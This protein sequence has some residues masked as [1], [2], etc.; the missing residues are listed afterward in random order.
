MT[1]VSMVVDPSGCAWIAST[2]GIW[3]GQP[4]DWRLLNHALPIQPAALALAI[5]S[6]ESWRLLAAGPPGGIV[7]DAARASWQPAWVDEVECPVTCVVASPQFASDRVL[8][9]GT[10]R[11]GVL[12]STDGGRHWRLSS[13]GLDELTVLT[14]ATTPRWAERELVFA[15]T[16]RGL[17][18]SPNGGRAWKLCGLRE[19]VVQALAPVGTGILA[20]TEQGRLFHSTDQ[21]M[22]WQPRALPTD[23]PINGL[24]ADAHMGSIV[25]AGTADGQL[26]RSTDGGQHWHVTTAHDAAVLAIAGDRAQLYAGCAD[27]SLLVSRDAGQTW[28]PDR[29]FGRA[30]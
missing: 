25:L 10:E 19:D 29:S 17:Y 21:G 11:A 28:L 8:L 13:A 26:L 7:I 3:H 20:G 1:I 23:A 14:L 22:T 18:R 27:E 30:P 15:G 24:W 4:G 12:R 2:N 16:T 6:G 9:A 5:D